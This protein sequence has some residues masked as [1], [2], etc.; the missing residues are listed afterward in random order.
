MFPAPDSRSSTDPNAASDL[1]RD[2]VVTSVSY[3]PPGCEVDLGDGLVIGPI[4]WTAI[5]AGSLRIW[6]PPSIGEQVQVVA[7]EGD[8]E[9]ARICQSLFCDAFPAPASDGSTRIEWA[10]GCW[11]GYDLAG[12]LDLNVPQLVRISA[13]KSEI[14]G[15]V[16][17]TGAVKITGDVELDGKLEATGDVVADTISLQEHLHLQPG[18]PTVI[19]TG[20]PKP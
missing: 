8:F 16:E 10:D 17:I 7:P 11:I 12:T 13:P 19:M 15:D 18:S 1:V 5:R 2:G 20:A 6:A 9:R 14:T 4:P 3:D